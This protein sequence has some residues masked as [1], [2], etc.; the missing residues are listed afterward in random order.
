MGH[1]TEHR[2]IQS[3]RGSLHA[4]AIGP[5][6]LNT[7]SMRLMMDLLCAALIHCPTK[8]DQRTASHLLKTL[9]NCLGCFGVKLCN[10]QVDRFKRQVDCFKRQVDHLKRWNNMSIDSRLLST[11]D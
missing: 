2:R 5:K 8:H 7:P 6:Q 1:G 10:C 3:E 4:K 11:D 9:K